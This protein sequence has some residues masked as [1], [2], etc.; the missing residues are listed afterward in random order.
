MLQY[1]QDLRTLCLVAVLTGIPFAMVRA[2]DA[3]KRGGRAAGPTVLKN[4]ADPALSNEIESLLPKIE[5][6]K[7]GPIVPIP[8][9]PPPHE[10]ALFNIPYIVEPPDIIDIE[11]LEAMPGRPITGERLVRPD[12][13]ISLDW[14]GDV[15]VQG[16]TRRQIKE[17]LTLHMRRFV[18]DESLGLIDLKAIPLDGA[19][20][21]PDLP[22]DVPVP[23]DVAPPPESSDHK[24]DGQSVRHT[25]S[26]PRLGPAAGI[27]EP[28]A[29]TDRSDEDHACRSEYASG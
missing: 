13:T 18:T 11:I 6:I 3:A 25:A 16:L 14:Y 21:I 24:T 12:G 9:D 19:A 28:E 1:L 23:D 22:P 7:P 5:S 29:T 8:D 10:G 4:A 27:A 26:P 2:D 20:E 15:Y 17:K